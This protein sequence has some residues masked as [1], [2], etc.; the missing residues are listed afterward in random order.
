MT[1]HPNATLVR[2]LF[3]AFRDHDIEAVRDVIHEDAVWR[4]PGATGQLAG[5]HRGHDGIFT[6]LLRVGELTDGTFALDLEDV[7]ANDSFAVA[8]F[9]GRGRRSDGRELDNPTVLKIHLERGKAVE[10]HEFVWNL[11][12]VDEF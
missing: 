7:V 8:M 3:A 12:D 9:R 11:Y 2:S 1:E 6:F 10:I 4:F 5:A